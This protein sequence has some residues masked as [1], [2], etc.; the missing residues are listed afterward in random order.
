MGLLFI[1]AAIILF[2]VMGDYGL[3]NVYKL[4]Q[5]KNRLEED[6]AR[7]EKEQKELKQQIK[8]LKADPEYIEKVVRNRYRMA[9]KGEKVFRVIKQK[10]ESSN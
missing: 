5:K 2:V 6:I 1:L 10:D 9:E 7:M 3:Y 4:E 8:K